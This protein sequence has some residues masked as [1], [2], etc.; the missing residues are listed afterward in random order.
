MIVTHEEDLAERVLAFTSATGANVVFD[1]VAG[2]ILEML[3]TAAAPGA[4]IFEYGA[5]ASAPTPLPLFTALAKGVT[6]RGYT[7]F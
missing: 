6:I 5:L 4:T 2:P 3:A 7:L 1:P